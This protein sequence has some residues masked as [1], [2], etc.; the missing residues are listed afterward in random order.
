MGPTV[1]MEI[2]ASTR[3][4]GTTVIKIQEPGAS[5]RERL[6][7]EAGREVARQTG[8]FSVPEIVSYDDHRGEIVF[9]RLPLTGIRALLSDPSRSMGLVARLASIL[10]AI[11]RLM[12]ADE[13]AT[14]TSAGEM[15]ISPERAVVPLHGDFAMS[16]VLYH[17]P[18]NGIVIIDW[19][20]ADWIGISADLGAPEIDVGFFVRSLFHRS[21][22]DRTPV[23]HRY[24]VARHFL[25]TYALA[26]PYGLDLSCLAAFVAGSGPAFMQL[27]RRRKGTLRALA[28]LPAMVDLSFFLRRLSH[29]GLSV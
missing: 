23:S 6:R 9:R 15:G 17:S 7:T 26:S 25:A 12:R 8:L 3:V 27:T 4:E 28:Y 22:L 10:A 2:R 13:S 11:H 16:N 20:N 5:R 21:P 14:R 18:S 1:K 19:C 29:Q 24:R